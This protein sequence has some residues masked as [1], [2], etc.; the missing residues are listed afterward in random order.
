[1]IGAM[2]RYS[3]QH[4]PYGPAVQQI[5]ST[6]KLAPALIVTDEAYL[7][8]NIRLHAPDIPVAAP[9]YPPAL[10][11]YPFDAAHPWLAIWREMDGTPVPDVHAS[12]KRWLEND[13][14]FEGAE[15]TTGMVSP[16]YNYGRPGDVYSFSYAWIRPNS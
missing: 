1:S 10:S 13:S 8:G 4:V 14:R 2:E 5:L 11:D 15:W 7:P 16:S 6:G 9:V 3:K 12:F